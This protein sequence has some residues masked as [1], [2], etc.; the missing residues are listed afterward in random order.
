MD[1]KRARALLSENLTAIYGFAFSRLYDKAKV[2]DLA[3]EIVCEIMYASKN[4]KN[5]DAFWSYAWKIAESTLKKFIRK[6]QILKSKLD[7]NIDNNGIYEISPEQ[8]IIEKETESEQLYLLRR[9]LSLLS[10]MCREI[11]ISYYIDNKTCSDIAK[12][13]NISVEMVKQYL[14]KTRKLLKEGIGMKRSLGEKSY[15][16]GTFKLNFW[17]DR[18][19]YGG[20]FERK[21]PQAIVL[22]AYDEPMSAEELSM[23][24]GVSMPYLEEEIE[25]LEAAGI[26][27]K[28]GKK[29]QTNIVILTDEYEKEV[30]T[31]AK[32][33]CL[34]FVNKLWDKTEIVLKKVREIDF[35][36]NDYEDNRLLFMIMN[37]AM[38]N[39]YIKGYDIA[40][41]PAAPKL[42]LG[43]YGWL[44]GHDNDFNNL[45]FYGVCM[46]VWNKERTAWFSAENYCAIEKAQRYEHS[47]FSE[48]AEAMCDAVLGNEPNKDNKT[49]PW[50]IENKFILSDGNILTANF[51]VFD[52][53]GYDKV[54]SIIKDMSEM[55]AECM[56]QVADEATQILTKH[57]PKHV[58][59]Q[60]EVIARIHHQ[61]DVAAYLMNAIIENGKLVVP[62]EKVPL[63]VFGVRS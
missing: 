50:L 61:L 13:K 46:E 9:E 8:K 32:D 41:L 23:E 38:V 5:K 30:K 26:L 54:C 7:Y 48:K 11:C 25:I 47:D 59:K 17:G 24:L 15:N 42:P 1:D 40:K 44:W 51:P 36:G 37:M 58:K 18:N 10:K 45:G 4:I 34:P 29:Y 3:S 14:F 16:P 31:K 52:K 35:Y 56:M 49:L 60:C 21:L 2:D 39:G 28:T 53:I 27:I 57:A 19:Y 33:I 12:E 62:D 55:V 43:S 6:E 22:S 20:L 63:C